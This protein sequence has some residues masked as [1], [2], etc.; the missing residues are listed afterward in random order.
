MNTTTASRTRPFSATQEQANQLPAIAPERLPYHKDLNER[1]GVDRSGWRVL[2]EVTYPGAKS[3][4]AVI[5]ALGYCQKRGLDPFKKPVHIVPVWSSEKKGYIETIWPGISELR[6]TA[7]R[8][9]IYAGLDGAV[10]GQDITETFKDSTKGNDGYDRKEITVTYPEWCSITVYKI[11]AGQRCAF[12]GPRIFY[13]EAYGRLG[14]SLLP[15]DMWAKRPRGQLEKCAEAAALRRAFPEEIGNEYSAEEM[16][17]QIIDHEPVAS[18][19]TPP[20]MPKRE[21][22]KSTQPN[23]QASN[24]SVH[25][26]DE[27]GETLVVPLNKLV[28]ELCSRIQKI[29]SNSDAANLVENNISFVEMLIEQKKLPPGAKAEIEE[30]FGAR[31]SGNFNLEPQQ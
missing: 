28:Q 21:D 9:G 30:A 15:N 13:K 25:L 1:F 31:S 24:E 2:V 6:T 18:G 7:T 22:F 16:E 26:H 27:V 19:A 4:E 10:F 17:G 11:V 23:E 8:T 14:K 3:V 20:P 12:P 5:M 29:A